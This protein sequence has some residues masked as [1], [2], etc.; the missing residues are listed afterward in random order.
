MYHVGLMANL[1]YYYFQ[2]QSF[3]HLC[4]QLSQ[5][6]IPLQYRIS[7]VYL[8]FINEAIHNLL[9]MCTK[10]PIKHNVAQRETYQNINECL[11]KFR[12]LTEEFN[13]CC[14]FKFPFELIPSECIDNNWQSSNKNVFFLKTAK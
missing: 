9:P 12:E 1:K 7:T 8:C 11:Q 2:F 14:T 3:Y 10:R 4:N 5:R 13:L 6:P